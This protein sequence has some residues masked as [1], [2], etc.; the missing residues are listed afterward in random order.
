MVLK[1]INDIVYEETCFA[2]KAIDSDYTE[3]FLPMA[4]R[5]RSDSIPNERERSSEW[6][7][8][9]PRNNNFFRSSSVKPEKWTKR[10]FR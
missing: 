8:D 3:R 1:P 9:D 5:D 4:F 10:T 2:P 6:S 7:D